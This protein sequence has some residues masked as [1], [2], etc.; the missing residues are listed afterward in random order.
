MNS[1][2]GIPRR[3]RIR[4][5]GS[6]AVA[7][8]LHHEAEINSLPAVFE[9]VSNATYERKPMSNST[10][11]KRV[12]LALVA[13]LGFAALTSPTASAVNEVGDATLTLSAASASIVTGGETAS[14]TVTTTFTSNLLTTG[15]ARLDSA[16]VYV[17]GTSA[18]GSLIIRPTQDTANAVTAR[19][20]NGSI[21]TGIGT[22]WNGT[23]GEVSNGVLGGGAES[24]LV[25]A[26]GSAIVH[27]GDSINAVVA[28][29][30]TKAA[31]TYFFAAPTTTG[32]YIY[33][34]SLRDKAN[35]QIV[36]S[37]NFTLTVGAGDQTATTA[38]KMWLHNTLYENMSINT[39]MGTPTKDSTLVVNA[40]DAATP[41]I[42]GYLIPD[43]YN[44]AGETKNA[45]TGNQNNESLTVVVSG[46]GLLAS[47]VGR[48]DHTADSVLGK[49]VIVGRGDT[50]IV[51]SDGT[52]GVGTF[53]GSIGGVNL[54]QAAKTITFVG[55]PASFTITSDSPQV[56]SSAATAYQSISFVAKD[57]AGSAIN[58]TNVQYN[59]GTPGAFYIT[60]ADTK[61]VS[62]T[63]VV[64][65]GTA[66]FTACAYNS[67]RLRWF[68]DVP[69]TDSGS[70]TVTIAD[71]KLA[72]QS[73]VT[74]TAT[75]TVVGAAAI[76]TMAWDKATYVPGEIATLTLTAKDR[77]NNNA[78]NG[79]QNPFGTISWSKAPIFTISTGSNAA[80]G[81]FGTGAATYTTL[82]SYVASG[83]T[84]NNGVDT[85]VVYMPQTA[86]TYTLTTTTNGTVY[87]PVTL[88][89]KV[90]DAAADAAAAAA[91]AAT[92]A[93]TAAA[94]AA[95]DAA[96][97]AIDAA[98][99]ATDAAN[100][101]AEAA[102]AATVAAEEARDAA[103]AATAAVEELAT[104]VATLMAA[105][106]AQ[107]TTLANTV[108]KIAKKV[109][110]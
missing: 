1:F 86:G 59:T 4:V 80:G 17:A 40:G 30:F 23:T 49:S 110:A 16:I 38:S 27:R 12:A 107:I 97:E 43:L 15:P 48:S 46:P 55:K 6:D 81:T 104:Q 93:S 10:A 75:Y 7:R 68:C 14:V 62:G 70:V 90:V 91:T 36:K 19:G 47:Y 51:Y 89:F 21:K 20:G 71:S 28:G 95:A 29:A 34:F 76:G 73:V 2:F 102:D 106:K 24:S 8:A 37:A 108:A 57:S 72:S 67:V 105:L 5:G 26:A 44:A 56:V 11:F 3:V 33:T 64:S 39:N 31:Y 9:K 45:T 52:A 22:S 50:V 66:A 32:T 61:V 13:T 99:A 78:V 54:T 65:T 42:V 85:A 74:A 41:T 79:A 92:A 60:V 87:T 100:L 103:D 18:G 58:G 88:T 82:E 25:V 53:T 77:N 83:T 84:Y 101:A 63:A 94:E 69:I 96:A 109:K 98:N 35:T